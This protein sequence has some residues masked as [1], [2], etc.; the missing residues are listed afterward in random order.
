MGSLQSS[1]NRFFKFHPL[2]VLSGDL[3]DSLL[4]ICWILFWWI[5]DWIK[6]Y[7]IAGPSLQVRDACLNKK[8][9][10]MD[11]IIL[12]SDDVL[13]IWTNIFAV[14]TFFSALKMLVL[15]FIMAN[16]IFC[17]SGKCDTYLTLF[18]LIMTLNMVYNAI[19]LR[20]RLEKSFW[21]IFTGLNGVIAI[22]WKT[23]W[24]I[25]KY[26]RSVEW[27]SPFLIILLKSDQSV[28][29]IRKFGKYRYRN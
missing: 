12:N 6:T 25:V 18:S 23:M 3:L 10:I 2:V 13:T 17:L 24:S 7:N 15:T 27:L 29:H 8:S 21:E 16:F 26:S 19:Y 28:S 11:I 22:K 4:V 1:S 9:F 5:V 14:F 20:N